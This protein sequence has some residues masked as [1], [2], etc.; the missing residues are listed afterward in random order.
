MHERSRERTHEAKPRVS[1]HPVT[2]AQSATLTWAS[3]RL[4]ARPRGSRCDFMARS[5]RPCRFVHSW[6]SRGRRFESCR[7]DHLPPVRMSV[8]NGCCAGD[9]ANLN[10]SV[11]PTSECPSTCRGCGTCGRQCMPPAWADTNYET[12]LG[13]LADAWCSDF[14][15]VATGTCNTMTTCQA[16]CASLGTTCIDPGMYSH[17]AEGFSVDYAG[18]SRYSDDLSGRLDTCA[19]TPSATSSNGG[20]FVAVSCTCSDEQTPSWLPELAAQ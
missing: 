11:H 16:C 2:L 15:C 6:G 8:Y 20:T 12:S 17:T 13:F 7:P 3:V 4:P 5:A 10:S 1:L 19:T 9:A 14:R 18:L